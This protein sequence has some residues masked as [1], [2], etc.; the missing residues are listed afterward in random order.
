MSFQHCV[1]DNCR[2]QHLHSL[3]DGHH[4]KYP[5]MLS[6]TC[7]NRTCQQKWFSCNGDCSVIGKPQPFNSFYCTMKQVDRH[8]KQCH[9]GKH[10]SQRNI[11][12][13][14][15]EDNRM[16]GILDD[17]LRAHAIT[18][19]STTMVMTDSL[20]REVPIDILAEDNNSM[21][22]STTISPLDELWNNESLAGD[23]D[24]AVEIEEYDLHFDLP[25]SSP[26]LES[27]TQKFQR[28]I[29]DGN[30]VS[31][32]SLLV[33]QAAFQ[34]NNPQASLLPLPNIMLFLYLA[35]L[36][37]STGCQQLFNLSQVL[38]ILYPYADSCEKDWAPIPC[39][40]SGFRS[41]FLN[42]SNSNSLVSILPIPRR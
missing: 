34:T 30:A 11:T 21:H 7:L 38:T 6:H 26:L 19:Q 24:E 15:V 36:V 10:P 25:G 5:W 13:D 29:V 17:Y 16:Q 1:I 31:A 8:H 33:A 40:V 14:F 42:V 4:P 41:R 9:V 37:I 20:S 39:T 3:P 18:Q 22:S 2:S 27:S 23:G 35:K 28:L 32:A 12:P